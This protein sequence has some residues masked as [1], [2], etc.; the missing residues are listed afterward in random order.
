[1]ARN[2]GLSRAVLRVYPRVLLDVYA[3]GA[4]KCGVPGGRTGSV[5][6]V[7]RAGSGL[8]VNL[9]FTPSC[10]T[11]HGIHTRQPESQSTT[12]LPS[13]INVTT[14]VLRRSREA[15][16][17]SASNYMTGQMLVMRSACSVWTIKITRF[18]ARHVRPDHGVSRLLQHGE[19]L[20]RAHQPDHPR[21]LRK[22]RV[23][24][25]TGDSKISPGGP[26]PTTPPPPH[27]PPHTPP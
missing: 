12:R 19:I 10:L 21:W 5:T 27:T 22:S 25:V 14:D 2:Q 8:N 1:M 15:G 18:R 24:S 26:C 9:H 6:V 17:S 13:V 7:Q 20:Q 3:R 11:A 16:F 4:R 23:R